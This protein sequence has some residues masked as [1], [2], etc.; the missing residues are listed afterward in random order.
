M[1]KFFYLLAL[2]CAIGAFTSCG[3]DDDAYVAT[4]SK[5]ALLGT[6]NV[7]ETVLASD[8]LSDGSV[9][10]NW[11]GDETVTF[12]V[13]G[14]EMSLKEAV[15]AAQYYANATL[16]RIL[17]SIT[18]NEDGTQTT[19]KRANAGEPW[20]ETSGYITYDVKNDNDLMLY[21][22][23]K[24]WDSASSISSGITTLFQGNKGKGI[25][26]HLRWSADKKTVFIYWDQAYWEKFLLQ[27]SQIAESYEGEDPSG[28]YGTH[29]EII[30]TIAPMVP[31]I[32]E[33]T[34]TCEIG[35]ELTR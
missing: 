12:N 26:L 23:D 18:F 10:I 34:E 19:V 2:V 35:I 15:D 28:E 24:V 32:I 6:W 30:K 9:K 27:L 20:Q 4:D 25:H 17:K 7:K 16:P 29:W 8:G 21:M 31:K 11:T 1:R 5:S 3:C 13:R 14:T 33:A 22:T